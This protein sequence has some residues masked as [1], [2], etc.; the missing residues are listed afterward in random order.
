[1]KL[2]KFR[3]NFC[4]FILCPYCAEKN[5]QK[6][7]H[8]L[9]APRKGGTSINKSQKEDTGMKSEDVLFSE[10][11]F[12]SLSVWDLLRLTPFVFWSEIFTGHSSLCLLSFGWGLSPKFVPQHW[13]S[14]FYSSLPGLKRRF[15]CVWNCLIFFV[16]EYW[17]VWPEIYRVLSQIQLRFLGG[18]SVK[19]Y[20]GRIF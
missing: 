16:G 7:F 1:M 8:I 12:S 18:I 14:I 6:H 19:N 11:R 4:N 13:Q 9:F 15:V 5:S 20:S 17:S 3:P 2:L 10:N